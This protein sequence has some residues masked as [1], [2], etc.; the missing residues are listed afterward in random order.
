MLLNINTIP[1]LLGS[2]S[3][4]RKELLSAMGITCSVEVREVDETFDSRIEVDQLAVEIAKKK[5]DAY[6][7]KELFD[8]VVIT[9]DT[10]VVD[11]N[12]IPLGKP[13]DSIEAVHVL[14]NLSGQC[15]FVHTGVVIAY[16][17][18]RYQ[19]TD[20]TKV[21]F[22]VLTDEEIS[23]YVNAY[24]PLDKAGSYGIQEWIGRVAVLKIEG[25]YENVIGLPTARLYQELKK[26]LIP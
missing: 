17:G 21:W 20:T 7:E 23:Y 6:F 9:A 13:N 12:G 15:H 26:I 8:T 2:Q 25:S 19:F 4:R 1:V 3:P 18:I 5:N 16:R 11:R 22:A 10:I 24:R 14:K